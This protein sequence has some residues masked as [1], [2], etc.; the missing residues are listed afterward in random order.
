MSS[1]LHKK[2]VLRY[3]NFPGE[4]LLDLHTPK[5]P[6]LRPPSKFDTKSAPGN[7]SVKTVI[8]FLNYKNFLLNTAK[9]TF[10]IFISKNFEASKDY[11]GELEFFNKT[12]FLRINLYKTLIWLLHVEKV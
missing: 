3:T 5:T 2:H 8:K 9:T 6:W 4:G 7:S 11:S 10:V 12:K 1:E